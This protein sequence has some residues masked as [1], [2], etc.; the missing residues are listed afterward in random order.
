MDVSSL[1]RVEMVE[2]SHNIVIRELLLLE[3]VSTRTLLMRVGFAQ[4]SNE[5]QSED[6]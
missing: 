2:L 5:Q 6:W 1:V 3:I 4:S